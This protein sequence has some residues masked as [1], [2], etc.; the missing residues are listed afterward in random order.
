MRVLLISTDRTIFEEGSATRRRHRAYAK[1]FEELHVVSVSEGPMSAVRDGNL[2][3]YPVPPYGAFFR[4]LSRR[5]QATFS[6]AGIISRY[7]IDVVTVQDPF[8]VGLAALVGMMGTKAKFHVQV[9]TDFLSPEYARLSFINRARVFISG[10]VLRRASR[11]RV[12]SERIKASIQDKYRLP[13][14]ITVLPIFTDV[15]RKNVS[16]DEGLRRRFEKHKTKL[17]VVSRLEP[18]KNVALALHSF[19]ESA[20]YD[21]CLI[22][23][24]SGRKRKALERQAN[25]LGIRDR[26]YFE[27][28]VDPT[29]Y[30]V[31]ADVILVTSQYEGYGLVIVEALAAGKP[32]LST[33]V[34]IA[35]EAGAIVASPEKFSD[36]LAQWFKSGP[37]EGHLKIHPYK[38]FEEYVRAYCDDVAESVRK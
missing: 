23:V 35:R 3:I 14:P 4:S 10:F 32:V 31:I 15:E 1:C 9:H 29:Q 36:A 37:R 26:V 19:A 11:I 6:I 27:G 16:S 28:H 12:V 8:E 21:S 18:E 38:N 20:P 30:Y 24:G 17:L 25:F 7:N 2:T 22:I 34:G 33:D 5:I 13:V